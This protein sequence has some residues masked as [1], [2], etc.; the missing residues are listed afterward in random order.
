MS[1][2]TSR[3]QAAVT[4][5]DDYAFCWPARAGSDAA[6]T[7]QT[8]Q[9]IGLYSSGYA[10]DFD[11]ETAGLKFL[12]ILDGYPVTVSSGDAAGAKVL[13]IRRPRL[14]E[15]PLASGTASKASHVGNTVYA[16]TAGKA[17]LSGTS[18]ANVLGY[19][20]D[21]KGDG[22]PESLTG[23]AVVVAP[24]AFDNLAGAGT[25]GGNA[26]ATDITLETDLIFDGSSTGDNNISIPDNFASALAIKEG[27]NAY[28]TFVTTNSGEKIQ[29]AKALEAATT[30][31]FTGATGVNKILMQDN[32]ASGLVIGESSNAYVTFV[33]TNS[34]EA[35]QVAKPLALTNAATLA[36]AGSAQGD[37]AAIVSQI[38]YVSGADGTVGVVLPTAAAGLIRIVYNLHASNGLKVYPA[39]GDDIND[40]TT[41]AAITIEGKTMAIFVALDSATWAAIYTAN[42]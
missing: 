7:Y 5:Y 6:K 35:V 8:G 12:G 26:T 31:T 25:V 40:G 11:D 2:P 28:V 19:L 9:L 13:R 42:S 27:S 18:N 21:V 32:L 36:A 29:F 20:V 17:A 38:A 4:G 22:M 24:P 34:G 15:L 39:S 30:L 10:G 3:V 14:L 23:T 1:N 16:S 33:T 37:A 41:D